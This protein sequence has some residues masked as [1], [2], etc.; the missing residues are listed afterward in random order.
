MEG[1]LDI[2]ICGL[3]GIGN[4]GLLEGWL[5]L[6][7]RVHNDKITIMLHGIISIIKEEEEDDV[8]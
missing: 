5:T 1:L 6:H 7:F 2:G 8:A 3:V 4:G